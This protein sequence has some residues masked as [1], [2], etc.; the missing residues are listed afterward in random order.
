MLRL[1][2]LAQTVQNFNL[3]DSLMFVLA[4]GGAVVLEGGVVCGGFSPLPSRLMGVEGR[5][6]GDCTGGANEAGTGAETGAEAGAGLGL[7]T[8][9]ETGTCS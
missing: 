3:K 5:G 2:L 8:G 7:G 9:T 6:C 4:V 1:L